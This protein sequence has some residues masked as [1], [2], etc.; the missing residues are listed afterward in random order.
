M[1]FSP[2]LPVSPAPPT[3]QGMLHGLPLLCWC[4]CRS[5][6]WSVSWHGLNTEL[7]PP[8]LPPAQWQGWR[9][10]AGVCAGGSPGYYNAVLSAQSALC[11]CTGESVPGCAPDRSTN[12]PLL[13]VAP[14]VVEAV[15]A[16][17]PGLAQHVLGPSWA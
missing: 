12:A 1:P 8:R 14:G 16:H 17:P 9:T 2:V 11:R 6:R 3:T 7:P 13:A 4:G 10:C 5:A 15:P